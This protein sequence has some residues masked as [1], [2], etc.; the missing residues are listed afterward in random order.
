MR[1]SGFGLIGALVSG[2]IVSIVMMGLVALLRT[3]FNASSHVSLREELDSLKS[4][5]GDG[6]DCDAT[7]AS[8][9]IDPAAPGSGCTSTSNNQ[10]GPFLTLMRRSRTGAVPLTA[11]LDASGLGAIGKYKLRTTCSQS[12]QSLIIRAAVV[13]ADGNFPPDP[14]TKQPLD[15]N[16]PRGLLYGGNTLALPICFTPSLKQ[17]V[18]LHEHTLNTAT[19]AYVSCPAAQT[20][21]TTDSTTFTA[22]GKQAKITASGLVTAG[23]GC[24][25]LLQVRLQGGAYDSGFVNVQQVGITV[26][27]SA[28]IASQGAVAKLFPLVPGTTYNLSARFYTINGSYPAEVSTGAY[29]TQAVVE[30]YLP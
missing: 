19:A 26:N 27:T 30:E 7:F 28:N 5:I 16:S 9:S 1:N 18:S 4:L 17:M 29:D 13:D 24:S 14:F 12:E 11:A 21:H 3:S 23:R 2:V 15:W 6:I 20:V 8:G 10:T 25:A 22:V